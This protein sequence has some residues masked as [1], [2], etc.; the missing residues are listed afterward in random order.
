MLNKVK[1]LKKRAEKFIKEKSVLV[2][3]F[4]LSLGLLIAQ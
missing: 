2:E 1:N 4:L 3:A